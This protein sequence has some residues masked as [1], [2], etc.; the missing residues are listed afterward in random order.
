MQKEKHNEIFCVSNMTVWLIFTEQHIS[1]TTTN[2]PWKEV[3]IS[4][5]AHSLEALSC[6]LSQNHINSN[7]LCPDYDLIKCF[8]VWHG[9]PVRP[10]TL[11]TAAETPLLNSHNSEKMSCKCYYATLGVRRSKWG[12]PDCVKGKLWFQETAAKVVRQTL[13]FNT[14]FKS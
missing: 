2:L 9:S 6:F 12:Y 3:Q 14:A 7:H 11:L 4:C 5:E 10:N 8:E 1:V 13:T